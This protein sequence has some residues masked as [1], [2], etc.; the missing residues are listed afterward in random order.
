MA[1]VLLELSEKMQPTALVK[2]AKKAGAMPYVQRLGYVLDRLKLK[3]LA[4]PLA[5]YV[6]Q[7]A[8]VIAPL[9]PS[10]PREGMPKNAKWKLFIN[11]E[12]EADL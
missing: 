1:T 5:E 12:I 8:Q 2:T 4:A 7:H 11:S 9:V 3:E 6:A 10:H